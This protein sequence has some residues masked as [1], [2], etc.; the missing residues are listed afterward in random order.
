MVS[1]EGAC[2]AYYTYGRHLNPQG[3]D[4]LHQIDSVPASVVH[5]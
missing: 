1:A 2:A 3:T 5:G 4:A